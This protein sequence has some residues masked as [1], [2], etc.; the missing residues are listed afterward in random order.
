MTNKGIV[1]MQNQ[2]YIYISE[3]EEYK[4]YIIADG[5]G[6]A[7]AG[8]IASSKATQ[9]VKEYKKHFA[10]GCSKALS[11]Q[12]VCPAKIETITSIMKRNRK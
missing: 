11:C 1:R 9:I 12:K 2:D 4:L 6:G 7:N 8:D 5:M 10:S 3:N